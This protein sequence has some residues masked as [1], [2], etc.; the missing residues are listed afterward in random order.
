MAKSFD[1]KLKEV[2]AAVEKRKQREKAYLRICPAI[3]T[4]AEVME[5]AMAANV[6]DPVR[7][8]IVWIVSK[9]P[10]RSYEP[11]KLA[12][13]PGSLELDKARE[14]AELAESANRAP[15]FEGSY[16]DELKEPKVERRL[17]ID[18][19]KGMAPY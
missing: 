10:R 17:P 16:P 14:L 7:Q 15:R 11:R 9:I 12:E 19:P 18:Y 13:L 1:R 2:I 3:E 6:Y 8:E 5:R 4:E